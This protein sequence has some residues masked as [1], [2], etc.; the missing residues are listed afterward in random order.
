MGDVKCVIVW[1]TPGFKV[2]AVLVA[3]F[4]QVS[5]N[6]SLG[7]SVIL[8]Y[9]RLERLYQGQQLS[10]TLLYASFEERGQRRTIECRAGNT[11]AGSRWGNP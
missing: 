6:Q 9:K 10:Q 7:I 1:S 8:G 3:V 4:G 2:I 5:G 11:L